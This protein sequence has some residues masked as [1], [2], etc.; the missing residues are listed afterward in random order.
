MPTTIHTLKPCIAALILLLLVGCTGT[1]PAAPGPWPTPLPAPK[2]YPTI[3]PKR[4]W[5]GSARL[6]TLHLPGRVYQLALAVH[7]TE[8]WPVI[9]AMH[10]FN[11]V[12]DPIQFFVAVFDPETASWSPLQQVDVGTARGASG[13]F[14]SIAVVVSGNREVHAIYGMAGDGEAGLYDTVSRDFGRTWSAPQQIATNCW[15]VSDAAGTVDGQIVVLG[16]C[17]HETG[18]G[19]PIPDTTLIVR[20]AD[21]TWLAPQT[22]GVPGWFGA[23]A[24]AGDGRDALATAWVTAKGAGQNEQIIY[25]ISKYLINERDGWSVRTR[26]VEAAGIPSGEMGDSH[27]HP[28]HLTFTRIFPNG[29]ATTG[30]VFVWSGQYRASAY[31]LVSLDGGLTWGDVEPIV[32]QPGEDRVSGHYTQYVTPAYDPAADRLVAIWT[33]CGDSG[34][35]EPSTHYASWSVPGS[36]NWQ[37]AQGPGS[38]TPRIPLITGARQSGPIASEMAPGARMT[39]LAWVERARQVEVRTLDLNTIIPPGEYPPATPQPTMRGLP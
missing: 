18:S 7:P 25:L 17:Y 11:L 10:R 34:H 32:W 24:L 14:G 1:P 21:G 20:R 38:Y 39:W 27:W 9:G 33:C 35:D 12:T 19:D 5:G 8:N 3:P 26:Q 30:I 13:P 16:H 36:G 4:W 23:I 15:D 6:T 31:A 2:P 29:Q 37:P 22:T 28:R